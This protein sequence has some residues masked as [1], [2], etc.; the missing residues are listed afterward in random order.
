MESM[1]QW[2]NF[3]EPT[4]CDSHV[5]HKREVEMHKLELEEETARLVHKY[6]QNMKL[7][8]KKVDG[9]IT[10]LKIAKMQHEIHAQAT[11]IEL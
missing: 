4:L 6:K 10:S 8:E 5:R 7:Y 1:N 9:M 2:V 3:L 11:T